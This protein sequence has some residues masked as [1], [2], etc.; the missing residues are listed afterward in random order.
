MHLRILSRE[1]KDNSQNWRKYL[2]NHTYL[3]ISR[4]YK[5]LLQLNNKYTN[6]PLKKWSK[7]LSRHFSKED[8][9][10]ANK[11]MKVTQHHLSLRNA[12]QNRNE[13]LLHIYWDGNNVKKKQKRRR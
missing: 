1:E 13:I 8:I 9:K 6:N 7:N 4:V 12:D 3:I 10:M 11:H 2:Q 5:E